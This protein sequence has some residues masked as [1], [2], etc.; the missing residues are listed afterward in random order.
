MNQDDILTKVKHTVLQIEPGSEIYLYGSRSR[1]DFSTESDW[2]FLILV[3]GPVDDKRIDK[4]RHGIYE[5][6]WDSG[7]ILSSIVRERKIW[8]SSL[9]R[10]LPLRKRIE[11]EGIHL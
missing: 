11:Q 1:G 6:E 10:N 3:D 5:I 7:E 4:I 2:D 9:Y 8:N